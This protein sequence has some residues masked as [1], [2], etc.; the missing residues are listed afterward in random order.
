M[1][2]LF[3]FLAFIICLADGTYLVMMQHYG[4]A[5]IPFLFAAC[6]GDKC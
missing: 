6:V 4:W 1:K 5:W 2:D 3:V